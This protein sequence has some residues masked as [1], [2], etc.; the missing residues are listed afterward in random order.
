MA[1]CMIWSKAVASETLKQLLNSPDL[2]SHKWVRWM[3]EAAHTGC[4]HGVVGPPR[5][6][7]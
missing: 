7:P 1:I 2:S 4:H 3:P 6:C 5:P